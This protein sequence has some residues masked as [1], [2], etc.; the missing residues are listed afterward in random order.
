MLLRTDIGKVITFR[1]CL[2]HIYENNLFI[3]YSIY[4][5]DG[6]YNK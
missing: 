6:L 1:Y 2:S 3:L 4:F 5:N